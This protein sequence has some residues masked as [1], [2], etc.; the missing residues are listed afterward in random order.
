AVLA[1]LPL[2]AIL[3][4]LMLTVAGHGFVLPSATA[5]ALADHPTVAGGASAALGVVQYTTGAVTAPLVG[6]GGSTSALPMVL[7][8]AA[9]GVGAAIAAT[10]L[11]PRPSPPE[12][13]GA[14]AGAAAG[15]T[16]R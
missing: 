16:A 3:P 8:M 4:A 15:T 6:L 2:G 11:V 1:D 14:G 10:A 9:L 7:L 12:R 5:L 13:A